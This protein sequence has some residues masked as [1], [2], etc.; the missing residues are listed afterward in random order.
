MG[1]VLVLVEHDHAEPP[2]LGRADFGDAVGEPGGHGHLPAEGHRALVLVTAPQLP[3][4]RQQ[5]QPIML[6]AQ[7]RLELRVQV[8]LLPRRLR[9]LGDIRDERLRL[10]PHLPDRR[11]VGVDLLG[12]GHELADEIAHTQFSRNRTPVADQFPGQLPLRRAVEDLRPGLGRQQQA[13][14]ADERS[15]VG[16]VR[17]HLGRDH[18]KR[19]AHLRGGHLVEGAA[20]R[21]GR[22]SFAN[23]LTQLAGRLARERQPQHLFG[24]HESVGHQPHD[25]GGHGLGFSRAGAGDDEQRLRRSADDLGLSRGRLVRLPDHAGQRHRVDDRPIAHRSP[26]FAGH[27]RRT[28]Q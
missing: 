28:P 6:G 17:G 20:G 14:L 1:G 16:V 26:S 21:Q 2:A 22:Q 10:L 3:D 12:Q 15:R 25:A 18:P 24:P 7:R 11:E 4:Q 23:A 27:A 5:R 9:G 8:L 13:V 19:L